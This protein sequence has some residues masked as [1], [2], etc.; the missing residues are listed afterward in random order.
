MLFPA[1]PL[2]QNYN[3]K[4]SDFGLAKNG[5]TGGDSHVTTRVMDT[6]GYAAPE[7]V[8][9]GTHTRTYYVLNTPSHQS[10]HLLGSQSSPPNFLGLQGTCT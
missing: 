8:A 7:Y 3:A 4:L 2:P 6:Y 9:T 1:L 5:P 10:T